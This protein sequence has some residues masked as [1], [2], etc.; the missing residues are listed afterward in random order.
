MARKGSALAYGDNHTTTAVTSPD[1]STLV[2]SL[3]NNVRNRAAPSNTVS[4]SGTVV[5]RGPRRDAKYG[6]ADWRDRL[7]SY[8]YNAINLFL[9]QTKGQ[10]TPDNITVQPLG[11]SVELKVTQNSVVPSILVLSE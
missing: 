2:R 7:E 5:F 4:F 3:S 8:L 10:R 6:V 9:N 1:Y 11:F